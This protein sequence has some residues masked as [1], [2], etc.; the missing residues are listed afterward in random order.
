MSSDEEPAPPRRPFALVLIVLLG[1]L[2]IYE[3]I[4]A[5]TVR[6]TIPPSLYALGLAG[7]AVSIVGPRSLQLVTFFAGAILCLTAIGLGVRQ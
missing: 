3:A 1:A 5:E 6:A 7:F 4:V 2:K